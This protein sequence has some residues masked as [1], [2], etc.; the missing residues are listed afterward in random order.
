MLGFT[1]FFYISSDQR[2]GNRMIVSFLN[3]VN[4]SRV[5]LNYHRNLKGEQMVLIDGKKVSAKI[6]ASLQKKQGN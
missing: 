6:R 2:I 5:L 4:I 1:K 3:S